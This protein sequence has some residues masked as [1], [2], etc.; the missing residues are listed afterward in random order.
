MF[1]RSLRSVMRTVYY[2]RNCISYI[3][4]IGVF[5]FLLTLYV[6]GLKQ[7]KQTAVSFNLKASKFKR[8][9]EGYNYVKGKSLKF[10]ERTKGFAESVNA[11]Y[12]DDPFEGQRRQRPDTDRGLDDRHDL[13]DKKRTDSSLHV[14]VVDEHHEGI[15]TFCCILFTY[16]RSVLTQ[17]LIPSLIRVYRTR[18]K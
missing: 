8:H 9:V 10:K 5:S 6:W 14:Y 3:S 2:R 18:R 15:Q 17:P 12:T 4:T 13:E 11:E 16:G 1:K 7:N